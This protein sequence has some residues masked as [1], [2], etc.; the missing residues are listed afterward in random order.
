MNVVPSLKQEVTYFLQARL[1][2]SEPV[3]ASDDVSHGD[4]IKPEDLLNP[5]AAA[6]G[7]RD[8]KNARKRRKKAI[9]AAQ[10]AAKVCLNS[11]R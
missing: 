5:E 11:V 9:L 10:A 3:E 2:E 8:G 4:I 1:E 7:I 6:S